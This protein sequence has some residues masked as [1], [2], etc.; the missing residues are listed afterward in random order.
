MRE[1]EKMARD[2]FLKKEFHIPPVCPVC[3][4][5]KSARMDA[6]CPHGVALTIDICGAF[7]PRVCL[8]CGTVYIEKKDVEKINERGRY[9]E[10]GSL[11]RERQCIN[12]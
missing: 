2:D 12:L 11:R 3:G 4:V 7:R 6:C 5:T 1:P 9:V 10:D 8:N